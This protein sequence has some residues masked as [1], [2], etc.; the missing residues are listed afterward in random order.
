M[1][2]RILALVAASVML[3]TILAGCGSSGGTSANAPA[4]STKDTGSAQAAQQETP[5][6]DAAPASE[7]DLGDY[8]VKILDSSIVTDWEGNKA[9]RVTYEF[10]NNGEDATSADIALY[11]H[12]YQN[13]IELESTFVG[14]EED[15][16][17]RDNA[18]KSIKTG[19]TL[20]CATC[21]VLSDESDVEVEAAELISLSDEKLEKTFTA[22]Q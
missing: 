20:T 19:V 2:K 18:E 9:I 13:G 3:L 16:V 12:A 1:K 4:D 15:D 10:T 6:E 8:H 17:E 11:F 14:H 5:K 22:A 21:F 7:G